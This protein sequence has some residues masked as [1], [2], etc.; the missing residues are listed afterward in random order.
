MSHIGGGKLTIMYH[1]IGLKGQLRLMLSLTW[2]TCYHGPE[3]KYTCTKNMS[4]CVH[5]RAC[6]P[7]L[8]KRVKE[9]VIQCLK[10]KISE[11]NVISR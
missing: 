8:K 9:W 7:V 1:L 6:V 4:V 5:M 3:I 11:Y 10:K 2:I